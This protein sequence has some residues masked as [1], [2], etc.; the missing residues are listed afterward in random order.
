MIIQ[1]CGDL[2]KEGWTR[3]VQQREKLSAAAVQRLQV[4]VLA[5]VVSC[6]SNMV[7]GRALNSSVRVWGLRLMVT[8]NHADGRH[9]WGD[10]L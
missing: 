5:V 10:K 4:L 7:A 6:S 8:A 1:G 3:A 2:I 9:D